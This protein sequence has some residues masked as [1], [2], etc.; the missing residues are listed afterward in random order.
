MPLLIFIK[1]HLWVCILLRSVSCSI[2]QFVTSWADTTL[3]PTPS[4]SFWLHCAA[5]GI[6]VLRPGMEALSLAV[7]VLSPNHWTARE[8]TTLYP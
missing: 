6:L 8:V 5:C 4:L 3:H 7:Q 2:V 1:A